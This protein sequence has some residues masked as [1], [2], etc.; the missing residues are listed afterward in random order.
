MRP[1]MRDR[2]LIIRLP[3]YFRFMDNEVAGQRLRFLIAQL[4]RA[5]SY[6][7]NALSFLSSQRDC[8]RSIYSGATLKIDPSYARSGPRHN[9]ICR[10]EDISDK[11]MSREEQSNNT[12]T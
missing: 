10:V 6:K 11:L 1:T 12:K 5:C 7:K 8:S 4:F 2:L 9:E 3:E